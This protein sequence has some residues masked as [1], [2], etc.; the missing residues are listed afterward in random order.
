MSEDNTKTK[1]KK[2]GK[3]RGFIQGRWLSLRTYKRNV[4]G[5]VI[6]V[7]LFVM[8]ITFKFDM[9]MKLAEIITLREE[10]DNARTNLISVTAKYGSMTRESELTERM[11]TMHLNLK[12]PEQPPYYLDKQ[13][14]G[15]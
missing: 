7:S 1:K 13:K 8:Y 3:L 12:V 15:K 2:G 4:I 11:D 10:L 14:H 9:Q 5:V 6:V